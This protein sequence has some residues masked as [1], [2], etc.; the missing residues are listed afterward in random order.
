MFAQTDIYQELNKVKAVNQEPLTTSTANNFDLDKLESS[1]VYHIS[2]IKKTCIDFRL[3]FLDATLFKGDFPVE[4][5]AQIK[6]IE[7]THN[8]DL[9]DLKLWHLLSFLNWKMPTTLCCLLLWA[10]AIII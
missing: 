10:M 4:A 8:T 6:S 5:V 3:R 1:R 7:A 9:T 2:Q